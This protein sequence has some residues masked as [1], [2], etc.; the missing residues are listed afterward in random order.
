M[1]YE[2][3]QNMWDI[4]GPIL[5]FTCFLIFAQLSRSSLIPHGEEERRESHASPPP[6][7]SMFTY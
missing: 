1:V 7:L 4:S 3:K 5:W 6:P 2:Q